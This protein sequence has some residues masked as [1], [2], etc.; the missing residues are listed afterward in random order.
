MESGA[1]DGETLSNTI[2]LERY[3]NWTGLLIEPE[4]LSYKKLMK[5]NRKSFT[6][7]NC[8]SLEKY[9]TEVIYINI[10]SDW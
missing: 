2:F 3:M 10:I 1:A 5:R 4:P 8:L 6:F 7:N 9:P